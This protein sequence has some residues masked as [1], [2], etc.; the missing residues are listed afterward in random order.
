MLELILL[1]ALMVWGVVFFKRAFITRNNVE[2]VLIF[3]AFACIMIA[4][5][6]IL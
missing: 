1:V 4:S 3:G 6:F 5:F 2:L